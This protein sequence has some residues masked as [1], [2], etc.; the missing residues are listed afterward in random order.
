MA[1]AIEYGVPTNR[2]GLQLRLGIE[3]GFF[4]EEG[5]DLSLKVVFGGPEIA[6]QYDSGNLKVGELGAP[7][8]LTSIANGARFKIVGSGVRRGAVLYLVVKPQVADWPKLAGCRLG[9]LSA[10]SCSDWFM[11]EVL[12][13]HRLDP[14]RDV[15]VVGLGLRYPQILE[16][17]A[18]GELDGGIISEPHVTI[19]EHAGLFRVWLGL[20]AVE[21]VPRMQWTIVV[22][23]DNV[24]ANEPQLVAAVMRGCRR[25]YR[26]G[27]EH[28][29]EWAEFG[30]RYF[31]VTPELMARSIDREL[32]DLHFDCQIDLE[33]LHAAVALQRRLGAFSRD[34]R[35]DEIADLRFQARE[36][37]LCPE[38]AVMGQFRQINDLGDKS[39]VTPIAAKSLHCDKRGGGP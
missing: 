37:V 16:L 1:T 19:G 31:G 25:S 36:A 11:R 29:V 32:A 39:V 23:N 14:E 20:N 7:P 21:F 8:G 35:L 9:V 12:T 2:C 24:L 28:P 34:L 26:Y 6:A 27:A 30:A 4:R 3:K 33:G 5:L 15:V 38:M 17:I 18:D 10:G 22:A 13:H